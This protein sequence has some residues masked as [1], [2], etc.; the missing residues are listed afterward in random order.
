ML[1]AELEELFLF[2]KGEMMRGEVGCCRLMSFVFLDFLCFCFC[3]FLLFFLVWVWW[4]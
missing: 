1:L 4:F 3:F 2:E